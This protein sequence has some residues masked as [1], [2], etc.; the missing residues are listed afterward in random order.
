MKMGKEDWSDAPGGRAESG[1]ED[2]KLFVGNLSY[3]VRCVKMMSCL[4]SIACTLYRS[5]VRE[6]GRNVAET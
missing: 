1:G 5:I 3:D 6:V 2:C 4:L